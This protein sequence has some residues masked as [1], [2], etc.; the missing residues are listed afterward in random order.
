MSVKT[1]PV[2]SP[3]IHSL[4]IPNPGRI[5]HNLPVPLLV[6]HSVARGE[7]YLATN[8]ALACVTG[9]Y[10]GGPPKDKFTVDEP[11]VPERVD[12]GNI[13]QPFAPEAFDRLYDRVMG[14]LQ[15][16]DLYIFDGFV[17]ADPAQR[18]PVRI[19][20]EFA[21]HNL[22]VHQLFIRPTAQELADHRPEFT[23]ICTPGF[24]ADPEADGTRSE[25]FIVVSFTHRVVIIGGTQYAGEMKKG[26]FGILNY[27][28]PLRG[29]LP[30]HCSANQGADGKV[31][32][33][34]GLSGTGKTTLSSDPTR[35]IIGDDEHGWT[36]T[37]I[38]NFEGGCYAKTIRLRPESEP[39]IWNA[40]R[41][42]AVLENVVV[43]PVTRVLDYDDE[44][45]TENTR[46]AY[47]IDF[48]PG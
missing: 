27:L 29:V 38:F 13:N 26:I 34:F 10:T 20:N 32:L 3:G 7:G 39:L 36:D 5:Y 37:G 22:F 11:E 41:F 46:A 6:E 21:W 2:H 8:G 25:A 9:R 48:L 31:A 45:L 12:W 18:L 35:R 17:G 30:M 43:D 47:P 15:G 19:I 14:Y 28:L 42:G 24:L 23:V 40:I 33:Y 4:G 16:R 1:F 44:S